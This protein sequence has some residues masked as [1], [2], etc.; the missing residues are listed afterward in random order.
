MQKSERI[1]WWINQSTFRWNRTLSKFETP[2][3]RHDPL[4]GSV[5]ERYQYGILNVVRAALCSNLNV[6]GLR[7][8]QARR[9]PDLKIARLRNRLIRKRHRS[10]A[11]FR[12]V[13][14]KCSN[15]LWYSVRS[16][17]FHTTIQRIIPFL[18]VVRIDREGLD[19][20]LYIWLGK[21]HHSNKH[22]CINYPKHPT[23]PVSSTMR[24]ITQL[25]FALTAPAT[26]HGLVF[27][28]VAHCSNSLNAVGGGVAPTYCDE[29]TLRGYAD[30]GTQLTFNGG[31]PEPGLSEDSC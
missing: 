19:V 13:T 22:I 18:R 10:L 5:A 16:S 24:P 6:A 8:R 2:F 23:N 25:I 29:T 31:D 3:E 15:R 27:K 1:D 28:A 14:K 11:I 12:V 26:I 4:Q 7:D 21:S 20:K 17:L 9:S 30:D